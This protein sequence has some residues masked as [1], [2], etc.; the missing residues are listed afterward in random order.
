MGPSVSIS[1]HVTATLL[2]FLSVTDAVLFCKAPVEGQFGI[3][4]L[5]G[6]V[7]DIS[8]SE[9]EDL[10]VVEEQCKFITYYSSSTCFLLSEIQG[11]ITACQDE[12]CTTSSSNCENSA[13][14][15]FEIGALVPNGVILNETKDI[16]LLTIGPCSATAKG[17]LAVVVGGG[18]G[19]DY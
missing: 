7:G 4:N 12:T 14:G 9:C 19:L 1:L 8:E 17:V 5:L 13:C 11:P 2:L 18:G 10:C 16:D 15:F 6:V 3:D